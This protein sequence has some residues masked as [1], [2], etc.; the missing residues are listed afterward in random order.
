MRPTASSLRASVR[1]PAASDST[2]M[3]IE[4]TSYDCLLQTTL[5]DVA[6][7]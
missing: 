2:G 7:Y 4:G 5:Y 6:H 3:T 1:A